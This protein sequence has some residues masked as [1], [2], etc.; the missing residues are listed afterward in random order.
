MILE[1]FEKFVIVCLTSL[2]KDVAGREG[3]VLKFSEFLTIHLPASILFVCEQCR[4]CST[5]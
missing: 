3:T 4:T 1:S 2:A 5:R